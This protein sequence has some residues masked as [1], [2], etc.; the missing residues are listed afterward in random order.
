M[1]MV[2]TKKETPSSPHILNTSANLM[3]LCF[4]ILTSIELLKI[5]TTTYLDEIVF[6]AIIL[7]MSSSIVSFLSM[8]TTHKTSI[9]LENAADYIFLSG[10]IVLFIT[11]ILISF[12]FVG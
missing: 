10:L 9:R 11:A 1:V 12:D 3:G 6:L 4:I 5:K 8:K 7:F 2:H